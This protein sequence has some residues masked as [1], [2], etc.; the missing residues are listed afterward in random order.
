[1]MGGKAALCP[2]RSRTFAIIPSMLPAAAR[3]EAA[4]HGKEAPHLVSRPSAKG[5]S[6]KRCDD[7]SSP[8]STIF[9]VVSNV[10]NGWKAD[11]P[12]RRRGVVS[13]ASIAPT[14][15]TG[16]A[17]YRAMCGLTKSATAVS[18]GEA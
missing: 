16:P 5:G 2:C 12:I 7:K 8:H 10:R 17:S 13:P 14:P 15:A 3:V 4:V 1:M 18:E 6:D 11:I 9:S